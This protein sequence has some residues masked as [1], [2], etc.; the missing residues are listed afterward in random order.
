[1]LTDGNDP[2]PVALGNGAG[3]VDLLDDV[4]KARVGCDVKL[5]E[6]AEAADG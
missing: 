6:G 2:D 4:E 1:M 3:V 5:N